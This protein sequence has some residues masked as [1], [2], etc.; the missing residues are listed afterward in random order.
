MRQSRYGLCGIRIG[1]AANPGPPK[2][3]LSDEAV[4]NVLSSLE[5][6]LTMFELDDEP[7]V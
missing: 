4:N 6:E 5:L 1:E 7:L 3:R 2:L